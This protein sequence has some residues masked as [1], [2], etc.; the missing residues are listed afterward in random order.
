[1]ALDL[2]TIRRTNERLEDGDILTDVISVARSLRCSVCDLHLNSTAEVSAAGLPQQHT[3]TE[4]ES[5]AERYFSDY[6]PDDY[7]ND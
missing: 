5:L 4:T 1:V 3:R 6:E 2:E 7:G